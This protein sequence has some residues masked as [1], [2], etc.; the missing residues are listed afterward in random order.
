MFDTSLAL[1][2]KMVCGCRKV[3]YLKKSCL[4]NYDKMLN[5]T[6]VKSGGIDI[7]RGILLVLSYLSCVLRKLAFYI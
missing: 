1:E 2:M 4:T 5:F 7:H 6:N 3:D